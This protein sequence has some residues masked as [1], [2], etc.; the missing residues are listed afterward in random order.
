MLLRVIRYGSV[1]SEKCSVCSHPSIELIDSELGRGVKSRRSLALVYQLGISA[2][3][4][5]V[6]HRR[7]QVGLVA[8]M[9]QKGAKRGSDTIERTT[10]QRLDAMLS[11]SAL[12]R[13]ISSL[14][15]RADR[16]AVSAEASNDA[17]TAL[18]AIR[19]LTRLLELQGRMTL[20]AQQGRAADIASHPVWMSLA[21]DI[22]QALA[23]YPDAALAVTAR[24]RERLGVAPPIIVEPES[25]ALASDS[26]P[27]PT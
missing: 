11:G 9:S 12:I 14:R 5:H 13:E 15:T 24:I 8:A 27:F 6:A 20:E 21:S 10:H 26:L 4:R 1:V 2:L 7:K 19:E 17:R 3:T 16:L 22:M 18:L 23:M 25:P